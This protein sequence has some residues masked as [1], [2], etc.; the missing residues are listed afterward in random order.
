[1]FALSRP[2]YLLLDSWMHVNN[3]VRLGCLHSARNGDVTLPGKLRGNSN[4]VRNA[5]KNYKYIVATGYTV[6][7]RFPACIVLLLFC[8]SVI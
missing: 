4:F 3:T 8:Y 5:M 1:M 7:S 6:P 2:I